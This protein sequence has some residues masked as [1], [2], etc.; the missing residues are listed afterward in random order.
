MQGQE[1]APTPCR[2][3]FP[4][5]R[6]RQSAGVPLISGMQHVRVPYNNAEDDKEEGNSS[7]DNGNKL[8][9]DNNA[10]GV[11]QNNDYDSDKD[12][13]VTDGNDNCF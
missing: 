2:G 13:D 3:L 4:Q 9:E 5:T 6:S 12:E 7:R 8:D 10:F 11:F 1:S